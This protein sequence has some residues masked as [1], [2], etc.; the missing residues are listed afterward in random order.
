M[1]PNKS[2]NVSVLRTSSSKNGKIIPTASMKTLDM[3]K[4]HPSIKES[5]S[6]D[7]LITNQILQL[8]KENGALK[9]L[10]NESEKIMKSA[11]TKSLRDSASLRHI[12]EGIWP[13]IEVNITD[14]LKHKIRQTLQIMEDTMSK[15]NYENECVQCSE[16]E[17]DAVSIKDKFQS[18][19][20]KYKLQAENQSLKLQKTEEKIIEYEKIIAETTHEINVYKRFSH[21]RNTDCIPS[22]LRSLKSL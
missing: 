6:K 7:K 17:D 8:K 14:E 18:E 13:V 22:F 20:T 5:D 2:R 21:A 4:R 10:L 9:N 16:E 11:T 15:P 12:I 1:N 3:S 19:Y